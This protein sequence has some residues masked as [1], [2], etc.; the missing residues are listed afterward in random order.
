[1]SG[2]AEERLRTARERRADERERK[3]R[4]QLRELEAL[5]R[6]WTLEEEALAARHQETIRS[7]R[8][9]RE[10]ERS[11]EM[12]EKYGVAAVI[13]CFAFIIGV[14]ALMLATAS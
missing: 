2:T 11:V 10:L 7:A 14:F 3:A 13:G 5:D 4:E 6:E 1:M 9:A 8:F 12:E